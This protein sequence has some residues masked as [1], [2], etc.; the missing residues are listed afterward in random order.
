MGFAG[1]LLHRGIQLVALI[2]W[3]KRNLVFA[4]ILLG[5][6]FSAMALLLLGLTNLLKIGWTF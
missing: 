4:K 3:S 5:L 2:E 6:F 1:R